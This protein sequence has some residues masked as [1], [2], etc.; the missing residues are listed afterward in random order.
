MSVAR[1]KTSKAEPAP[2]TMNENTYTNVKAYVD[3]VRP[4]FAKEEEKALFVTREGEAFPTGTIGKR[5][6]AW[7]K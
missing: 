1:H 4:H 7:W 3:H 5:V 2:I 6:S